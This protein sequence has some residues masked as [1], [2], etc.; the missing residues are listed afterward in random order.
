MP[1]GRSYGRRG[2]SRGRRGRGRRVMSYRVSRGGI[3]L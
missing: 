1:R 3:R 2:R